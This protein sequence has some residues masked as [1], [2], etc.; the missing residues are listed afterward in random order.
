MGINGTFPSHHFGFFFHV[1]P[2]LLIPRNELRRTGK[3]VCFEGPENSGIYFCTKR[4][5]KEYKLKKDWGSRRKNRMR[6]YND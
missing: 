2:V 5:Y 4:V 3:S 1:P 6:I